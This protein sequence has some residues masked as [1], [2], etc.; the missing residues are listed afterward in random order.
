LNKDQLEDVRTH[1][2]ILLEMQQGMNHDTFVAAVTAYAVEQHGD[3]QMVR[4][5]AGRI[6]RHA[7]DSYRK[8]A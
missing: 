7:W 5:W 3:D 1:A 2:A 8:P 6:G 4:L